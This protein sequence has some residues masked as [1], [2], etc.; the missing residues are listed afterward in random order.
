MFYIID[1]TT[2]NDGLRFRILRY[3]SFIVGYKG[4]ECS[5]VIYKYT[6]IL[7]VMYEYEPH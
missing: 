6:S 7:Y 3:V 2:K 1:P 4:I 5:T